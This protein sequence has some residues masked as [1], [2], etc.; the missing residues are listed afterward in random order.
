[1]TM[2]TPVLALI[3]WTLIVWLWLYATRI[4]AMQKAKV[5]PQSAIHPGALASLPT[6]AR[7]V[8]DNY[9]HLHEQPTIFYA[10]ALYSHL[11]GVGDP[12]N[13]WLAWGYVALR[14]V[15]SLVQ[16]VMKR[17]MIRFSVFVLSSLM[18]IAIAVRNVWALLV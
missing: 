6:D 1:M 7:V 10:L 13:V 17:V 12:L 18:L 4:P 5:H 15:H 3:V 11:V 2:M 14:V 16:I 9:N 8:A